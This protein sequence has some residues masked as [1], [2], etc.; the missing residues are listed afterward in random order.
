MTDVQS[1]PRI[2]PFLVERAA[3]MCARRLRRHYQGLKGNDGPMLR[4]RVRDRFVDC[5]RAAHAEMGPP[6]PASF[7]DPLDLVPEEQA[8]FRRAAGHYLSLFGDEPLETVVDDFWDEPTVADG[9]DFRVGGWIDLVGRRP[10]GVPELRQFELW[11]RPANADPFES[12]T[13][14]LAALRIRKHLQPDHLVVR[15]ADLVHG[16]ADERRI[17]LRAEG[18]ALATR[19][20]QRRARL[21]VR[22]K[23]GEREATPGPDCQTCPYVQGCPALR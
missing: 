9:G 17:D 1:L 5:A 20:S 13:I 18:G 2:T 14:L 16:R 8:V 19:F 12:A 23:D 22:V 3:T 6:N 4:G 21:Q 10:D 7:P 11:G 15:H